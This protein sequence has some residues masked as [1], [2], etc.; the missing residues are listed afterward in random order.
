[1]YVSEEKFRLGLC[2]LLF[3]VAIITSVC[4]RA[5]LDWVGK[6]FNGFLMGENRI[7]AP[8]DLPGWSGRDANIPYW[9]QLVT[10]DGLPVE[11]TGAAL[12]A[13]ARAG[14]DAVLRYG[15]SDGRAVVEIPVRVMH[16]H[17]SDWFG[18][19]ANYLLNG[20]ALLAIGFFVA[21]LRPSLKSAHAL[22]IFSLCWGVSLVIGLADFASFHFRWLLAIAE[23]FVPASLFYLTLCFPN[24]RPLERHRRLLH[25]V[26]GSSALLAVLNVLLYDLAPLAWTYAYRAGVLWVVAVLLLSVRTAWRERRA[27]API[28]REKLKIVLLGLLAAF[29]LPFLVLGASQL[30]GA[31]LPLN[32]VTAGWWIFPATLA[33][34]IFERDLFEIDIF[35]RRAATWVILSTLIFLLYAALLAFLNLG[36]HSF[37]VTTSPWFALLFSLAVLLAFHPLREALQHAVDRLLFRTHYNYAE[38]TR[39]VSQALTERLSRESIAEHVAGVVEKTMSPTSFAVYSAAADGFVAIGSDRPPLRV[40]DEVEKALAEDRILDRRQLEAIQGGG[41]DWGDEL[42]PTAVILPLR[43]EDRLEGFLQ[44]GPKNSGA[45]YGPRDLEL[46]RTLA[47]QTAMAVR[48]AAAY[49]RVSELLASLETRVEERTQELQETQAELR[50]SNEKLRELDRVKTQFFADA[51]HELRTPLTLVLGP[52]E[53]LVRQ[54]EHLPAD[55]RRMVELA[56]GNAATLLVLT[57]TLLDISRVDSGQMHPRLRDEPLSAVIEATAEPFRWLA[58]Q[59]G[60]ALTIDADPD[61]TA[62]CDRAMTGKILGNL[63]ANALKF[64]VDGTVSIEARQES[65]D[66]GSEV[67]SEA[68]V[69][70]VDTGP[71]IAPEELPLI[72]ERYRQAA[73]AGRSTFTGSGIGLSL[74]RELVEIQGGR[75]EVESVV[76]KGSAFRI[77]LP[78][79]DGTSVEGD[80]SVDEL[81]RHS[82]DALAASVVGTP[83]ASAA[84][85]PNADRDAV[86][87]VDDNPQ[88]LHF[89]EQMLQ[90]DYE[91]S[92]ANDAR[93]ALARLRERPFDLIVSDVMMPGPDGIAL[94]QTLKEDPDLRHTPLILLTARASLDSKLTGFAAGA[95]DYLTKPFHPDELKA[96]IAALLR[97]RRMESDLRKSHDELGIAYKELRD[98][99]AQL[100]HSE[101]MAALGTLVAGVAHEINNPVSFIHSSIDL[102][103]D[104]IGELKEIL[105][106]TLHSDDASSALSLLRDEMAKDDRFTNLLDN[107]A[108]CK[109]GAQRAARIVKDL[110]TFSRPGNSGIQPTNLHDS[111]EQSLR[112]LQGEFK[113][114]VAIHREF[115]DLPLVHCDGGQISQVFLN[116]LANALQ[117]IPDKGDVTLRTRANGATVD[118]EVA[119]SG[120]GMSDETAARIFDPF[121]TTKEVG[122]GTGLGLSIV[123]SLVNAH[124]GDIRVDSSPGHGTTFTV[125]LPTNGATHDRTDTPA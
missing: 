58:E 25:A 4:V 108:I 117:A 109:D 98:A 99:Q 76:G 89:L 122:K 82:L 49:D 88:I 125:T 47:N 96:R 43:F 60:V 7:V 55:A 23:G 75:V 42:P 48:N 27:V 119:D 34:A 91:V 9:S 59:R 56:R 18:L 8:I 12:A 61:L 101:K 84:A 31:E 73:S 70:V 78:I 10:I 50:Q 100:V 15:F 110:R 71:G 85:T 120:P 114:R 95:D 29:G 74:V 87:V 123:R 112:L 45:A 2:A 124:G 92:T 97:M 16:F 105:D 21:F 44:V 51:S 116:L 83:E 79:A 38:I 35:L 107:A 37:Q 72:F 81:P 69:T 118:V 104:S 26:V 1:M 30:V 90:H 17:I 67:G 5:S 6:P 115:G 121:F 46:L 102:I 111:L 33:Y 62:R 94:C 36:F 11:S 77:H 32:I 65:S 80:T 68:V 28:E 103:V 53:E 54:S 66:D 24:E 93:D 39:E 52:L 64:T 20:L 41:D 106:R 13:A 14:T 3:V 63:L 57:D 40:A 113:G 19:F 86:L 22:L